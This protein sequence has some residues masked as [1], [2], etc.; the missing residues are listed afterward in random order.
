MPHTKDRQNGFGLLTSM[1]KFW[2]DGLAALS[3]SL[4]RMQAY[5]VTAQTICVPLQ[6]GLTGDAHSPMR[7]HACKERLATWLSS[8][9]L[10]AI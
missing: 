4:M 3:Q 9:I 5:T 8:A 1:S 7:M 2:K 6:D 10:H